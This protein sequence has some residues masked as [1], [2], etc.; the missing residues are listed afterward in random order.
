VYSIGSRRATA[1]PVN[2]AVDCD[3]QECSIES[4]ESGWLF[5]IP[6][7]PKSGWLLSVGGTPE[8]LLASSRVVARR[9]AEATDEG[10]EFIASPRIASPVC[11]EGWMACGSAAV[12]FDPICGDGTAYAARE[13]ILAAAVINASATDHHREDLAAH[14]RSRVTGGFARHLA[15]CR[16][17]YCS[18]HQGSW[19][20]TQVDSVEQ[21]LRWCSEV[22]SREGQSSYQLEDFT[23]TRVPKK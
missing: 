15:L 12:S 7:A 18:G 8:S 3:H 14:Y 16:K 11:G 2:L 19:W 22:L 23:L 9:I 21:G 13:A 20:K 6:N 5:L 17:L 4:V 1:T 10:R